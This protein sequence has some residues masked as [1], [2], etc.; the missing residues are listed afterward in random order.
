MKCFFTPPGT[1]IKSEIHFDSVFNLRLVDNF[2]H[3]SI[4]GIK[5]LINFTCFAVHAKRDPEQ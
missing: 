5:S 3:K 4:F 1:G 2:K